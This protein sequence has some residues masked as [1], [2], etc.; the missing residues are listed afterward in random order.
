VISYFRGL[1]GCTRGRHQRSEKRIQ[2]SGDTYVSVC[3]YCRTP[4]RRLAKR[5]WIV[6]RDAA[7]G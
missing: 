3:Q 2:P 1:A 7:A 5:N 4:M 6:D